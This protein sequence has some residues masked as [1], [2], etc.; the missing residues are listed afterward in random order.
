MDALAEPRQPA[1]LHEI[2]HPSRGGAAKPR[3][4]PSQPGRRMEPPHMSFWDGT[5]WVPEVAPVQ[6]PKRT[7]WRD[8]AATLSILLVGAAFT[9]PYASARATAP[10]ITTSPSS[11]PAGMSVTVVG[12]NFPGK[13][14]LQLTWDG[15]TAAMPSTTVNGRNAFKVKIRVPSGDVG[16]HVLAAA[17]VVAA[18]VT[19]DRRSREP[20]SRYARPQPDDP[21]CQHAY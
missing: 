13:T 12:T 18:S 19:A 10:A 2:A 14:R 8:W 17:P 6:S 9:L 4:S 16:P 7:P 15:S 20:T 5:R 21:S 3:D 1:G 11:G